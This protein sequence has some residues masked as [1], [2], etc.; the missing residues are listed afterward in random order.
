MPLVGFEPI[1]PA[2]ERSQ[3]DTLDREATAGTEKSPTLV[4]LQGNSSH[5]DYRL[6]TAQ[7]QNLDAQ[8]IK[9][10]REV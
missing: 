6:F 5:K 9:G 4:I 3:T 2:G 7:K 1:I 10:D 8:N